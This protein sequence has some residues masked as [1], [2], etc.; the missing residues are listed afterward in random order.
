[1]SFTFTSYTH[2]PPEIEQEAKDFIIATQVH[3]DSYRMPYIGNRFNADPNLPSL[4]TIR[5]DQDG[6]IGVWT[7]YADELTEAEMTVIISPQYRRQGLMTTL[8]QQVYATLRDFGIQKVVFFSESSFMQKNATFFHDLSASPEREYLLVART[9]A[10]AQSRIPAEFREARFTD[11]EAIARV[12]AA[13]FEDESFDLALQYAQNTLQDADFKLFVVEVD[14]QVVASVS[15]GNTGLRHYL[16][17][18]AVAPDYQRQGLAQ[19]ILSQTMQSCYQS[20]PAEFELLVDQD[21]LSALPLYEKLGFVH[22][23]TITYFQDEAF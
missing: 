18:V 16:F 7:I 19:F 1:M 10:H 5:H 15:V 6:L 20:Q 4:W 12:N 11:S 9:P 22:K 2:V 8:K 23:S 14:D 13:S 21:N 3:D 17:G